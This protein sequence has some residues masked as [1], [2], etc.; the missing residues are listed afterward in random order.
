MDIIDTLLQEV[1]SVMEEARPVEVAI[2]AYWTLVTLGHRAALYAGLSSTLGGGDEHHHGKGYPVRDCG[3]LLH[4]PLS[5]LAALAHS[6]NLLEASVGL[7]TINALLSINPQ[8]GVELNAADIVAERGAGKRVAIVGHFPFIERIRKLAQTLWVL[9][10]RPHDGD[11]PSERAPELLPQADVVALT[12]TALL[13]G[14]F[15][16]LLAHCRSDAYVLVLG[17]TTPLSTAFFDLGIAAVSGT[18]VIDVA[19][20]RDSILQ[21]ATYRQIAGKLPLTLFPPAGGF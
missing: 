10:L 4:L 19:A 17:G 16:S 6:E 5:Q 11:E 7:A 9:E 15:E 20:A 12:G 14:T 3:Q 21:G 18:Q 8:P 13:N 1:S 2:G